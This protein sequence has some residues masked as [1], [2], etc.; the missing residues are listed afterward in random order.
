MP[1][2]ITGPILLVC[3][4]ERRSYEIMRRLHLA[5]L[6]VV[7]P[8]TSAAQAMVLAGQESSTV[9]VVAGRPTGRRDAAELARDLMSAWGINSWV[10]AGAG[11]DD[12]TAGIEWS[13]DPECLARLKR[14]LAEP[15]LLA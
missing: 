8:V 11:C 14:A 1:H 3:D 10:L 15:E 9:A 2:D 4:D 13:R 5:G 6:G 12:P 7:G